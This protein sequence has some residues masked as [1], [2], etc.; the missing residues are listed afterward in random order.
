MIRDKNQKGVEKKS[1]GKLERRASCKNGLIWKRLKQFKF[2]S[3]SNAEDV[4]KPA[5]DGV[6]TC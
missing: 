3:L 1:K 5:A 4:V 6:R 2:K